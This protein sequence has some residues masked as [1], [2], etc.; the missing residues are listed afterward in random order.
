MSRGAISVLLV[1]LASASSHAAEVKVDISG[2]QGELLHNAR[3]ARALASYQERDV[4]RSE[5]RLVPIC[6]GADP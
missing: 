4:S 5:V 1:L 2:I 6:S 3:A